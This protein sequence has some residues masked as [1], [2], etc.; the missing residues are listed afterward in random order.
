MEK[1]R[2]DEGEAGQQQ[3]LQRSGARANSKAFLRPREWP[4]RRQHHHQHQE[5]RRR[6]QRKDSSLT[7][8]FPFPSSSSSSSSCVASDPTK[9]GAPHLSASGNRWPHP[10]KRKITKKNEKNEKNAPMQTFFFFVPFPTCHCV[11]LKF[12]PS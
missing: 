10:M 5:K 2:N 6:H 7:S 12:H 11:P 1:G 9:G 8:L 3:Q 4:P